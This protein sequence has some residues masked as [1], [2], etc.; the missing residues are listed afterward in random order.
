MPVTLG[1]KQ[2]LAILIGR[3]RAIPFI[4]ALAAATCLTK[5]NGDSAALAGKNQAA[6]VSDAI[7]NFVMRPPIFIPIKPIFFEALLA[8]RTLNRLCPSTKCVRGAIGK[9]ENPLSATCR[10]ILMQIV[11]N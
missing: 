11:A 10:R 7:R 9:T 1:W 6:T 5:G 4:G 8:L 2:V 3:C